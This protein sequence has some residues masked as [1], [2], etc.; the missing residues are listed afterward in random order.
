M[1]DPV[2]YTLPNA[3]NALAAKFPSGEWWYFPAV[4]GGFEQGHRWNPAPALAR[5]IET[6]HNGFQLV[7][8]ATPAIQSLAT[9]R[10]LGIPDPGNPVPENGGDAE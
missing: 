7:Y 1:A 4:A 9:R 3:T 10:W 5:L 8:L 6:S 2:I